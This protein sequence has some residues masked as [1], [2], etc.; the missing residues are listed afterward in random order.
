MENESNLINIKK[1]LNKYKRKKIF[2]LVAAPFR[3]SSDLIVNIYTQIKK[4]KIEILT[5][6][7]LIDNSLGVLNQKFYFGIYSDD[8]LLEFKNIPILK[9]NAKNK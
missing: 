9:E 8:C 1:L 5:D 2:I 6:Y 4:N 7:T 3:T